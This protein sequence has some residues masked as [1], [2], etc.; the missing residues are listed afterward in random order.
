MTQFEKFEV[1]DLVFANEDHPYLDV[2]GESPGIVTEVMEDSF[3]VQVEVGVEFYPDNNEVRFTP[4]ELTIVG[5]DGE[6]ATFE[7]IKEGDR[8]MM[9]SPDDELVKVVVEDIYHKGGIADIYGVYSENTD[10]SVT[11]ALPA[12]TDVF[13]VSA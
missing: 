3:G 8:I 10:E 5:R 4:Q 11:F 1:G 7:D 2:D 6:L 9:I 12:D 13:K